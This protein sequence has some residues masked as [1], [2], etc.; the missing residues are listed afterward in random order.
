MS[1]LID[2]V[3]FN[4]DASCLSSYKWMKSLGGGKNSRLC[5]MLDNYIRFK[6]KVNVGFTGMTVKDMACFNPEATEKINN[7]PEVFQILLRTYSHDLSPLRDNKGFVLNLDMGLSAIK[8]NFKN[9][10][11]IFLQN[12]IIVR[13]RGIEELAR[14]GIRAIFINRDK[15]GPDLKFRIPRQ[16][17]YFYGINDAKMLTIPFSENLTFAYLA[18]LH[19][20]EPFSLW[21]K[22][23]ERDNTNI[24]WRDGESALLFPGGIELEGKLFERERDSKIQTAHISE[25][26]N[27]FCKCA[28]KKPQ[29]YQVKH[30]PGY[31]LTHW[32][33]DFKMFSIFQ[34]IGIVERDIDKCSP[35][36]Q[37][38]WTMGISSDIFSSGKMSIRIK[39]HKDVFKVSEDDI[40]WEGVVADRKRAELMLLRAEK[41]F[42]AEQCLDL[43]TKL[44]NENISE[45]EFVSIVQKSQDPYFKKIYS[46]VI[47]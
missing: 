33:S 37:R 19:G 4:S 43:L 30:F 38:L 25:K 2:I 14:K 21:R 32:L 39:V 36:L 24:L 17:F 5:K 6:R 31:P 29:A 44:L 20:A 27:D 15:Y 35:L 45:S 8:S 26:M 46:R 18:Q 23:I 1:V 10:T 42:E 16:S 28:E 7:H 41:Y 11:D 40:S 34:T 47:L 3:N 9:T 12:E 13:N 22:L